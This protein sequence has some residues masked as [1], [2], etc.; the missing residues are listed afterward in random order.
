MKKRKLL[1]YFL[2][3]MAAIYFATHAFLSKR[4]KSQELI[5]VTTT[6]VIQRDVMV[7]VQA[8]GTVQAYSSVSIQSMVT[9]PLI[10]LGFKEG[11]LVA[12]NQILFS[13]D[14]RPFVAE[15]DQAKANLVRDQAT[16]ANVEA[17][18]KRNFPLLKKGYIASQDYDSLVANAKSLAGTVQ[19]DAAAV[20]AAELQL[21]YTTIRAPVSG[22]TGVVSLRRG[23]IVKENDTTSLVTINQIN[24]IYVVFSMP[25]QQL[26]AVM[27]RLQQQ[28]TIPVTAL[29]NEKQSAQGKLTFVD[30]T[31]DPQT[32]TVQLKATFAN[33]QQ[34]LWPGQF[35]TVD[36][37]AE[38]IKQALLIPSL[39]LI[40]GQKGFFVFVIDKEA[41]VHLRVVTT[42]PV[43][44]H[45]TVIQ[46][47]LKPGE[48]IITAGQ[49]KLSGGMKVKIS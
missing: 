29:I 14:P 40:T 3:V 36:F 7:N 35:V 13:I 26:P 6:P 47:G 31:I 18:V 24:P 44:Q 5:Q 16:L 22:K 33:A 10:Q 27:N 32:G 11:E 12:E 8:I 41:I 46:S 20:Q 37:P 19:A 49:L 21:S 48:K 1:F 28:G 17:Q 4:E 23:S 9:G 43:I 25:Q 15:V 2:I 42:G 38:E 39:A 30:N 45:H 34:I